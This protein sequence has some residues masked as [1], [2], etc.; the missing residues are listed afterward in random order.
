MRH[1]TKLNA[2]P[3]FQ[4]IFIVLLVVYAINAMGCLIMAWEEEPYGE[5]CTFPEHDPD[6]Q[7]DAGLEPEPDASPDM[8][9]PCANPV[10]VCGE[11]GVTYETA[12]DA[13]RAHVRIA[14]EGACGQACAADVECQLG[15]I[16]GDRGVCQAAQ[17]PEIADGDYSQEVC[18]EDGFTYR[19]ACEARQAHIGV[20]HE[21]CCI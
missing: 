10:E 19:S 1:T 18:G 5:G 16:C 6:M 14:Y 21:G 4:S 2:K 20:L 13:S 3:L 8:A 17:C 7:T 11:D 15:D 9:A 12:C